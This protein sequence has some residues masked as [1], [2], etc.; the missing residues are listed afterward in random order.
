MKQNRVKSVQGTDRQDRKRT[1]Q[2]G[3]LVK[4]PTM[5]KLSNNDAV[6]VKKVGK[7]YRKVYQFL[8]DNSMGESIDAYAV[9]QCAKWIY[10]SA[11]YLNEVIMGN[12]IQTFAKNNVSQVH[13]KWTI[14]VTA[15]KMAQSYF[16]K[17]GM[18]H[19]DREKLLAFAIE[20]G[21]THDPLAAIIKP[22]RKVG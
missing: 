9:A 18:T 2:A 10:L 22:L 15:D 16:K 17:F 13:P 5:P 3:S 6:A 7:I 14:A 1:S 8:I 19:I 20:E 12:G 11:H 21:E 4:V